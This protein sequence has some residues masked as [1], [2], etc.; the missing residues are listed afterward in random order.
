[1]IKIALLR[2]AVALVVLLVLASL[3]LQAGLF[4]LGS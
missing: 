1:M 3:L 4:S 2:I